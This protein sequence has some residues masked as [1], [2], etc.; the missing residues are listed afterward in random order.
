M[1]N[2]KNLIDLDNHKYVMTILSTAGSLGEDENLEVYVV[3]G[4]IRD[5]L[6]EQPL[7]DIDLMVVGDGIDFAKK[8]ARKLG[9]K[10]IVPFTKFGTAIIPNKKMN[11]EVATART[12]SY[13]KH[14]RKPTEVIY[15]SL[16]GD[17]SRRDFTI[18][19]MAMNIL[20][21]Q[22][23]ELT[24]P[25]N[26]EEDIKSKVLQTPLDPNKTFTEDPLRMMRAAYFSSKLKFKLS[27]P[28]INSMKKTSSRIQIVSAERIRDE[29]IKILK[30]EKP[31]I[32]I[33]VLQKSGLLKYVFPEID[34]MYGMDQTPEWQHKDI[35][36]HTIQV[37]DN[38]A[39]LSS[40]MEIRF[41]ALVHDIAKPNTRRIDKK[42]GYTFHGH[43]AV[44]ERMI[45]TVASRMK[46]PNVL[47]IY[48][49]KLT[50][51][52][53]RPISLVK[54]IV[55]DSAVRRLMIAA[56]DDLEDLMVLCRADITTKNPKRVKKYLKNF[57][58]VEQKMS[59][60]FEKDSAKSF[61]SPVRGREIMK[62]CNIN[63]GPNVGKIKKRIEEA[64]LNGD[65]QNNHQE[66]LAFLM[67]IKEKN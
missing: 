49:K 19:A 32:G 61:Q 35:F 46:L 45:N 27:Q 31:S 5:L 43:D 4:F 60:V 26:G 66:A 17:L 24:D 40:K 6:M 18:N 53:L 54:D 64:I 12:E 36:A 14:S 50:L 52:H 1:K 42:K 65:I 41:A 44:G 10:K 34:T 20:P 56:G 62:I 16:K 13:V 37:V 59:S 29:F 55:T 7:N 63:E 47:K 51:L 33:I 57:E 11:I 48:L 2:I 58:K 22:F 39:K 3:G 23:G 28:L 21:N 25:Y 9:Q 8:L 30:T 67:N 38:A 15:T